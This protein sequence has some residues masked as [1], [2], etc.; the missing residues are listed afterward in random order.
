MLTGRVSLPWDEEF[1]C[2]KAERATARPDSSWGASNTSPTREC[3]RAQRARMLSARTQRQHCCG[4]VLSH[5]ARR[6]DAREGMGT[7]AGSW[8]MSLDTSTKVRTPPKGIEV[9]QVLRIL[10]G[11][12]LDF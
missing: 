4:A 2:L 6:V 11:L 5:L 7:D 10:L 12:R 3:V 1:C 9:L 8:D